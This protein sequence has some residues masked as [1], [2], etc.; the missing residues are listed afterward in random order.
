VGSYNNKTLIRDKLVD[1][2]TIKGLFGATLTGSCRVNMEGLYASATYPQ[3]LIGYGGG[4]TTPGM[5]AD[6]GEFYITVEAKGTGTTHAYKELGSFRSEI[7]NILDDSSHSG[8]AVCYHFRKFSEIEG[9]DVEQKVR[10]IRMGFLAKFK[11]D[12]TKP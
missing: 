10:W 5:G 3:V 11:Q 6:D 12:S 1:D 2:A 8:T 4:A 9:L 7:I